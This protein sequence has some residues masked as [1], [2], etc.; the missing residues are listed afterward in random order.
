[1]TS[2]ATSGSLQNVI[3]HCIKLIQHTIRPQFD[4]SAT[5]MAYGM[6]LNELSG[7]AFYLATPIGRLRAIE[8]FLKLAV[9][10][11]CFTATVLKGY[12]ALQNERILNLLL[13]ANSTDRPA[14]INCFVVIIAAKISV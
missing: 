13:R 10:Y 4:S 6:T 5:L 14:K 7:A 2:E 1:M 11:S 12:G 8:V 9:Y 3:M